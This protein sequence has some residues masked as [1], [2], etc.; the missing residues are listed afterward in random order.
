MPENRKP[1]RNTQGKALENPLE[2]ISG[3]IFQANLAAYEA[4]PTS[5]TKTSGT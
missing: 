4:Q 1:K 2:K 3:F 5:I